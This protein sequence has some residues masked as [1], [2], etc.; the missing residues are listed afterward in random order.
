MS[1]FPLKLFSYYV[2]HGNKMF[3]SDY[4][5][6]GPIFEGSPPSVPGVGNSAPSSP[7]LGTSLMVL[8]ASG[9]GWA[10]WELAPGVLLEK[11]PLALPP[12]ELVRA[13]RVLF[14][15]LHFSSKL[16]TFFFISGF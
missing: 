13:L 1:F 10:A 16:P 8:G 9:A 15:W 5:F 11:R 4:L 3:E 2:Q 14:C 6:I 12:T 7:C